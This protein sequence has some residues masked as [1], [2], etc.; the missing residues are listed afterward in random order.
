[1]AGMSGQSGTD[2]Y[3]FFVEFRMNIS[4]GSTILSEGAELSSILVRRRRTASSAIFFIGRSTAV[5]AGETRAAIRVPDIHAIDM[6]SGT[7]IPCFSRTFLAPTAWRSVTQK[8][9]SGSSGGG[10]VANIFPWWL[11]HLPHLAR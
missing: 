3:F 1:M 10:Y 9:A 7:D 2:S 8:S 11:R 6:V 4:A 5:M